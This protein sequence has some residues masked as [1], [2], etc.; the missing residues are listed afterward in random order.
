[1]YSTIDPTELEENWMKYTLKSLFL[2][3]IVAC[4]FSHCLYAQTFGEVTGRVTDASGAVMSGASIALTNTNTNAV[5]QAASTDAG[6]Y[7]FPSVPPGPY[8]VKTEVQGFKTWL[9]QPF[10]VQVQQ[11]VRLDIVLQVGQTSESIE[12][13]APQVLLQ[14]ENSTLGTV[15]E[16]KVVTE[17]PLNGRQYL[18]LVA[19]TP[20]ANVLSPVAG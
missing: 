20:N 1:V 18:N 15:I 9:S 3:S 5:R 10:Q 4:F 17:L 11:V 7:T 12:V 19:L 6:V 8:T 13:T 2:F 16:N 14:A